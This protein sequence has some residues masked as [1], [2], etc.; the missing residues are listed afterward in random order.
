ML[1]DAAV[2]VDAIT[3]GVE[4]PLPTDRWTNWGDL[5]TIKQ[6]VELAILANATTAAR[7]P[8]TLVIVGIVASTAAGVISLY[9]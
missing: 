6:D 7:G 4:P 5:T 1:S 2:I 8:L 9:L 3:R